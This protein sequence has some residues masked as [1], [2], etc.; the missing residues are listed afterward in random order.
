MY[1][2]RRV[3]VNVTGN[4][5]I[6]SVLTRVR[7]RNVETIDVCHATGFFRLSSYYV[8]LLTAVAT[9]TPLPLVY[10]LGMVFINQSEDSKRK[11]SIP[12]LLKGLILTTAEQGKK[13]TP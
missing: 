10:S 8:E 11:L 6:E 3:Y 7:A 5:L 1:S 12:R 2:R 4:V 9:F 13:E